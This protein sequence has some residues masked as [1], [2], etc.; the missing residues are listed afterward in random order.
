MKIGIIQNND[1]FNG[2]RERYLKIPKLGILSQDTLR[3]W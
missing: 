1:S 3:I 2:N